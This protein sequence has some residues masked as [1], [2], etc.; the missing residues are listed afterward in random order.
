MTDELFALV[1]RTDSALELKYPKFYVGITK[2]GQAFNFVKFRPQK[3]SVSVGICLDETE[4][5]TAAIDKT[6]IETQPYERRDS[7]YRLRLTKNE[8]NTQ[9]DFLAELF[10]LAYQQRSA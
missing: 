3:K 10:K 6:N 8:L 9:G 5:Q 1:K 4:E 7:A 2:A